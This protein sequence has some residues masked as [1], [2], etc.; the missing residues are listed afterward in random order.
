MFGF[1]S[2]FFLIHFTSNLICSS[3]HVL[4]KCLQMLSSIFCWNASQ[5]P[6]QYVP[7]L[8][9]RMS[10]C[11]LYFQFVFQRSLPQ[12]G[13]LRSIWPGSTLKSRTRKK[14][15]FSLD[16][17]GCSENWRF[18]WLLT[19]LLQDVYGYWRIYCRMSM[20][21]DIFTAGCLWLLMYLLQ[22][23]YGYWR[24]YCR[25][26]IDVF[27][28]GCL[29]LL[30][31]LLQDVYGYWRIYCWMSRWLLTYLLQDVYGHWRIYCRMSMA[32]DVFTAGCLWLLMYLLQDVYGYWR[33]YCRM[34]MAIDVF[35]AGCLWLLTYLLL[36]V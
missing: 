4:R 3:I 11:I 1:F 10:D 36:D 29:W 23:V 5:L 14:R 8:L 15:P 16:E 12:S 31:Y 21:I 2:S 20:A 34:S 6:S 13:R 19:Y 24:I 35:T 7:A 9:L 32:I 18:V 22:D 27:T 28:A 17:N 33:I 30:T 26:A 25:M